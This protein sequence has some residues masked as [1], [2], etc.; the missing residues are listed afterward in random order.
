[1]ISSNLSIVSRND[2]HNLALQLTKLKIVQVHASELKV[3]PDVDSDG[4]MSER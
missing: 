3:K 2:S 1:M 4:L